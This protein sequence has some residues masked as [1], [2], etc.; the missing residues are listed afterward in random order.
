MCRTGGEEM[1][2]WASADSGCVRKMKHA[3]LAEGLARWG[4]EGQTRVAGDASLLK[5]DGHPHI[6]GSSVV[7]GVSCCRSQ[8]GQDWFGVRNSGF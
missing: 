5:V 6:R 1:V 8:S 7:S 3:G 2:V 4:V